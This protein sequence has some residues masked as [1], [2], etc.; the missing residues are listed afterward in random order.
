MTNSKSTSSLQVPVYNFIK[1]KDWEILFKAFISTKDKKAHNC[2]DQTRPKDFTAGKSKPNESDYN[3]IQYFLH[4]LRKWEKAVIDTA[5]AKSNFKDGNA[6]L[7]GYLVQ[8]ITDSNE[9]EAKNLATHP[10]FVDQ[11]KRLWDKLRE[12]HNSQQKTVSLEQKRAEFNARSIRK[13]ETLR[14]FLMR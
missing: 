3:D 5:E 10:D 2:L 14:D 13:D 9:P 4:E 12:L 8:A 7:W 1:Y 6:T 11:G